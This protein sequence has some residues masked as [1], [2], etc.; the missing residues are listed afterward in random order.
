MALAPVDRRRLLVG[1]R[2]GGMNGGVL[3]QGQVNQQ[4]YTVG[5]A[6]T[7]ASRTLAIAL[8]S[9]CPGPGRWRRRDI[10]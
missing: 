6:D 1:R 5:G 7:P 9:R 10:Q 4:G 2:V 3:R 8:D